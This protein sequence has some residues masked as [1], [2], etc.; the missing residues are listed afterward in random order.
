MRRSA[1]LRQQTVENGN[2]LVKAMQAVLELD[3]ITG[4]SRAFVDFLSTWCAA[5]R[6]L[7]RKKAVDRVAVNCR[8]DRLE[9]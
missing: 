9:G 3:R 8:K 2:R 1:A 6:E 4:P 5:L 7:Y